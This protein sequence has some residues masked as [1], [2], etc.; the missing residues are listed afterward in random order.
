LQTHYIVEAFV[1]NFGWYPI[2]STGLTSPWP[3]HQQVNVSIV[4][5]EYEKQA[6]P[7]S[8]ATPPAECRT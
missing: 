4:P 1:P 3:N 5:I 8:A 6:S 2:E 7:N